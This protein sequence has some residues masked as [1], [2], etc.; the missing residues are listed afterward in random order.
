MKRLVSIL[1][2]ILLISCRD[3]GGPQAARD[4]MASINGLWELA[5]VE[6]ADGPSLYWEQLMSQRPINS[7]K[8]V[9]NGQTIDYVVDS[10]N[11]LQTTTGHIVPQGRFL[12]TRF[13]YQRYC[14]ETCGT[15]AP[16][17]GPQ[18]TETMTRVQVIGEELLVSENDPGICSKAGQAGPLT[19][20]YKKI[21]MRKQNV[22]GK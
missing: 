11:C 3:Q 12:F 17:C 10:N 16:G 9:N 1:M 18:N 5:A 19:T 22:A 7:R 6:C 8:H 2:V 15:S 21:Q 20:R 4:D 14:S 13:A